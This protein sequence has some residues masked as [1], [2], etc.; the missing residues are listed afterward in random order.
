MALGTF[1]VLCIHQLFRLQALASA[2][3]ETLCPWSPLFS[4]CNS[5]QPVVCPQFPRMACSEC[6]LRGEPCSVA[7][8]VRLLWRSTVSLRCLGV[9]APLCFSPPCDWAA[10]PCAHRAGLS[11]CVMDIGVVSTFWLL[12]YCEHSCTCICLSTRTLF[13]GYVLSWSCWV[14]WWLWVD[15]VRTRPTVPTVAAPS[16]TPSSGGP[17]LPPPRIFCVT[18]YFP[19]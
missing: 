11:S 8:C 14:L 4:P 9:L 12:C 19:C 5:P 1:T 15:L 6:F 13:F 7:I 2:Q 18:R 10:F 16:R 3:E 17:G